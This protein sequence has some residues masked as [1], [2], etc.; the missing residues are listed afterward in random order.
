MAK[1]GGH[2]G[3]LLPSCSPTR[4]HTG[5]PESSPQSLNYSP[6]SPLCGSIH[7]PIT[8]HAEPQT[9]LHQEEPPYCA[10]PITA[11]T[12]SLTRPHAASQAP[13]RLSYL[14]SSPEF[15]PW[16]P[17]RPTVCMH[18]CP[19]HAP[20]QPPPQTVCH[21]TPINSCKHPMPRNK[22]TRT[23]APPSTR[24]LHTTWSHTACADQHTAPLDLGNI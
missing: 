11:L 3:P 5:D 8:I 1:L 7:I 9:T 12:P 15:F 4:S 14:V 10:A 20:S 6:R 23:H 13:Q 17:H 18:P 24:A 16:A 21:N 22:H 19:T 2:P